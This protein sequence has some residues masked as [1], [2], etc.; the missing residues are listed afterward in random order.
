M[1]QL[2]IVGHSQGKGF[3]VVRVGGLTSGEGICGGRGGRAN[4]PG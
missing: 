3:I 2:K 1:R 4:L